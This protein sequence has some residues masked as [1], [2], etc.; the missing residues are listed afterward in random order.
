VTSRPNGLKSI[1]QDPDWYLQLHDLGLKTAN[2]MAI[3]NLLIV[4]VFLVIQL[5]YLVVS[6][7]IQEFYP[8]DNIGSSRGSSELLARRVS[9]PVT[10]GT[11]YNLYGKPYRSLRVSIPGDFNV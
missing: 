7:R 8:F 1:P 3:R 11:T 6:V 2:S 10:L 5:N 4:L 9:P